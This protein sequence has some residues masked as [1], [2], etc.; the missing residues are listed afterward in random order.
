MLRLT[1]C[2]CHA[3]QKRCKTLY[4]WGSP[5]A[6]DLSEYFPMLFSGTIGNFRHAALEFFTPQCK[7]RCC[8]QIAVKVRLRQPKICYTIPH[9]ILGSHPLPRRP[10]SPALSLGPPIRPPKMTENTTQ[11]DRFPLASF[12]A[13]IE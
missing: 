7:C 4:K 10:S 2:T 1:S 13:N 12:N 11:I 6:G 5:N 8:T 9:R 3:F